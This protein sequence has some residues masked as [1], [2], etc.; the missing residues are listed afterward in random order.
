MS[1]RNSTGEGSKVRRSQAVVGRDIERPCAFG[2]GEVSFGEQ[3]DADVLLPDAPSDVLAEV[4]MRGE[5]VDGGVEAA[6]DPFNDA[7]RKGHA[8]DGKVA[9]AEVCVA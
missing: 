2:H 1:L 4:E 6:L 3:S 8:D 7:L 9:I 5:E